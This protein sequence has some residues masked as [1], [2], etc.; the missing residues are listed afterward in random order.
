MAHALDSFVEANIILQVNKPLG[1]VA[2][3]HISKFVGMNSSF[4]FKKFLIIS[5][6][7]FEWPIRGSLLPK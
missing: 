4:W 3:H 7:Y 5:I 2:P 6:Y 1:N